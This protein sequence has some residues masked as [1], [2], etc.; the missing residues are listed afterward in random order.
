MAFKVAGK[1]KRRRRSVSAEINVTPLVDVMLVLLVIFMAT[2]PML[3]AGVPI[4]IPESQAG[5]IHED[6]QGQL[7]ADALLR[8]AAEGVQVRLLYDWM[9]GFRK[10]SPRCLALRRRPPRPRCAI[11]A[12]SCIQLRFRRR[13]CLI[14]LATA[15]RWTR[16]VGP[17]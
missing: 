5:A 4:D 10:T 3:S 15:R 1:S 16:F 2:A 7:F 17:C 12:N 8:K 9:G 6:D 11:F 14:W 13:W